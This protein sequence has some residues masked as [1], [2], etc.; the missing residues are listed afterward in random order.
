MQEALYYTE[1]K[2]DKVQCLL[3]PRNC[4]IKE[5]SSGNCGTRVNLE[6]KLNSS[7]YGKIAAI[8]LDPVEKKPLYHFYP[9]E[10]ILSV[11]TAGCNLHCLFCQN[12]RLSQ[13]EIPEDE[14]TNCFSPKELVD[15]AL[16]TKHNIGIA[17]TYN[18]PTVNYEFM[19]DAAVLSKQEGLATAMVSNGY[20]NP[21]PMAR[22][23]KHMDAFNIDL[24]AFN[25]KF[26]RKFCKARM[27]P[28]L[29]T[30]K[31]IAASGKLLELTNLVIPGLND[32]VKEFEAMCRWIAGETGKTTVLHLSRYFPGH[33]LRLSPT[34][35][36]TMF[37][38]YDIAKDYLNHVYLGNMPAG[39][40]QDT[41]C[42]HC[43]QTLIVRNAYQVKRTDI[44]HEG[45]CLKCKTSVIRHLIHPLI[46]LRSN[47]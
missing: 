5:G 24:K 8:N 26:Y 42:P 25:K 31:G 22:L 47:I 44:D 32:R 10:K 41:F 13:C 17:F 20:I 45:K 16:K 11:G 12:H 6:G 35:S 19:L 14:L 34:P 29:E 1:L 3:C 39:D 21:D 4:R 36:E 7:V 18:E 38:L 2:K 43:G 30:I 23:L 15:M 40:H 9:G 46:H 33:Q 27:E 28:V 37:R